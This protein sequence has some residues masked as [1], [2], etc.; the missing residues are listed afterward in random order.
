MASKSSWS[1][2]QG[3]IDYLVE[4]KLFLF[5]YRLI[6]FFEMGRADSKLIY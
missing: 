3:F 1:C 6:I 4:G 2:G 5:E